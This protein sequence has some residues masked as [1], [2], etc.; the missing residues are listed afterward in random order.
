[1]VVIVVVVIVVVSVVVVSVV[2]VADSVVVSLAHI[3]VVSVCNTS[4][5]ESIGIL[6]NFASA[7]VHAI[8]INIR[9][10][11]AVIYDVFLLFN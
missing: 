6:N 5:S 11:I 1:V 2:V 4:E 8:A 3:D 7:T 10:H 9:K